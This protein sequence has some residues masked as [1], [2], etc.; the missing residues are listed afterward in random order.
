MVLQISGLETI[1][2]NRTVQEGQLSVLN[3]SGNRGEKN[4]HPCFPET[5]LYLHGLFMSLFIK[6]RYRIS[7]PSGFP[8][9]E[10]KATFSFV[11]I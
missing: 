2:N 9:S 7:P 3:P 11:D 6:I 1:K 10:N 8:V 4:H 5:T